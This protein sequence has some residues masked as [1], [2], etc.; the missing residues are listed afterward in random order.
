M[1]TPP[2]EHDVRAACAQYSTLVSQLQEI[3]SAY[4]ERVASCKFDLRSL[5]DVIL[6]GMRQLDTYCI[7]TRKRDAGGN[8]IYIQRRQYTSLSHVTDKQIDGA[9]ALLAQEHPFATWR[10]GDGARLSRAFAEIVKS[11]CRTVREYAHLSSQ[12]YTARGGSPPR[13]EG[14]LDPMYSNVIDEI[15]KAE[16]GLAELCRE[17]QRR[18]QDL[19]AQRDAL[20]ARLLRAPLLARGCALGDGVVAALGQRTRRKGVTAKAMAD[21]APRVFERCREAPTMSA[22]RDMVVA[23]VKEFKNRSAVVTP[24]VVLRKPKRAAQ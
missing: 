16:A 19:K 14:D 2:A 22:F 24:R 11:R 15:T 21:L 23:C 5:R 4:S 3:G 13:D 1:A 20:E 9:L 6:Q 17:Q 12:P 8:P 7:R 18:T 10:D